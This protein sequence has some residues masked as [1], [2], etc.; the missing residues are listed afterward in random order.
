MSK[1]EVE[2]L[3]RAK[4]ESGI[5]CAGLF[6]AGIQYVVMDNVDGQLTFTWFE[7]MEKID[8]LVND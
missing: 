2:A 4:Y 3:L 6:D 1:E 5:V 8:N 7:A